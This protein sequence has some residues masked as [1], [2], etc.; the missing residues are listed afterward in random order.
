MN[1]NS[2]VPWNSDKDQFIKSI[3]LQYKLGYQ[4]AIVDVASV[5]EFNDLKKMGLF[6]RKPA[7]EFP[8]SITTL[9]YY[10]SPDLP[11]PIIPRITF[12]GKVTQNIQTLKS[13]LSR[14]LGTKAL[15]AVETDNETILNTAARD[16]RVDII[17]FPT[18]QHLKALSKGNLSLAKQN[19]C[20][21]DLSLKSLI[22]RWNTQKTRNLRMF[23]RLF[24]KG[25]VV[26]NTYTLGTNSTDPYKI[27]GPTESIAIL[28]SYFKIPHMH[29]KKFVQI[30]CEKLVLR[31]IKRDQE[32]FISSGVEIVDRKSKEDISSTVGEN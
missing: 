17:S 20:T 3:E 26:T 19:N 16:G 24:K 15:L 6:V 29:A 14:A 11:I 32:L 21:I 22:F 25:K 28:Q 23:Y 18:A 9:Q 30:N 2:C 10:K 13:Q 31:Y 12:K 1:I 8:V 7:I 5:Q 27:R 4:A